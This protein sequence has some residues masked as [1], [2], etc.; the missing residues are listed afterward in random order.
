MFAVASSH[1]SCVVKVSVMTM[2]YNNYML[3]ILQI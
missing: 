1:E 2:K 3:E